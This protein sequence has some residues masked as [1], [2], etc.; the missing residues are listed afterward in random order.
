VAP[1]WPCVAL[2]IKLDDG[3]PV[4]YGQRRVRK[5]GHQFKSWKFRSM[6]ADSDQ[7]F[8]PLQASAAVKGLAP[9]SVPTGV[10][11]VECSS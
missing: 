11:S 10:P 5:G 7:H 6:V 3:G 9:D 2:A 8:D 1:L 4:F